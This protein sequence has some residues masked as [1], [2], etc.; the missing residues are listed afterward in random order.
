[1]KV[2]VWNDNEFTHKEKLRDEPVEIPA[3][4]FVLME[5]D[6]AIIFRGQYTPILVD[7]DG[8]P[9]KQ[10]YKMIRIERI[11][12]ETP[13]KAAEEHVCMS[14]GSKHE[15]VSSLEAHIDENHLEQLDDPEVAKKRRAKKAS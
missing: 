9:M 5:E 8:Q 13:V 15:S 2:R 1:M 6:D 14:C 7:Y 10:S 3:K 4:R 11:T 12:D